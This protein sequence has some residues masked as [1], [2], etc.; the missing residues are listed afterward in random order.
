MLRYDMGRPSSAAESFQSAVL[1]LEKLAEDNRTV[2]E[3]RTHWANSLGRLGEVKA[4]QGQPGRAERFYLQSIALFHELNTKD[5]RN[6]KRLIG[7]GWFHYRLG[8]LQAEAGQRNDGLRS[9]EKARKMQAEALEFIPNS[10]HYQSDLLW[11]EEQIGLLRVA[12]GQITHAAQLA[13]QQR[14]LQERLK[15]AD[16]DPGNH[17]ARYEA[18]VGYVHLAELQALAGGPIEAQSIVEKAVQIL[19]E[20][21]RAQPENFEFQRFLA[22]AFAVRS[23]L[24]SQ[25]GDAV[26][27]LG[28]AKKAVSLV[29]GKL[30]RGESAYFYD[31]A[32]HQALC[33]SLENLGK[34]GPVAEAN[35]S[36]AAG[37]E[38]LQRA[39]AAGYED[40]YKL[41]TDKA[42]APLRARAGF[43]KMLQELEAKVSRQEK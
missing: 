5:P 23:R 21:T 6:P 40:V 29:E 39:I 10:A 35:Q 25:N 20:I 15:L 13:G 9:C 43:Q 32:C 37:V 27:A 33:S 7:E 42:L 17:Q 1:L 26:S 28:S 19:E 36:A 24:Q 30:V 18:A 2:L 16:R 14:V 38:A 8:C 41:K 4:A 11:S 12:M 22:S 31:L 3:Y 34:G